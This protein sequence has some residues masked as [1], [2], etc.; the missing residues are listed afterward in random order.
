M[1][2]VRPLSHRRPPPPLTEFVYPAVQDD[3][4]GSLDDNV[5]SRAKPIV[6]GGEAETQVRSLWPAGDVDWIK[7]DLVAN[8]VYEFSASKL[9]A[10]C[11]THMSL[12]RDNGVGQSITL[13]MSNG[14]WIGYDSN[15]QYYSAVGGI[16]YIEVRSD[17]EFGVGVASYELSARELVN[18]DGDLYSAY[19]DCDDTD[20]AIFPYQTETAGDGVDQN[21][22]WTDWPLGDDA[23]S[24]GSDGTVAEAVDMHETK[25][26]PFE[27]IWQGQTYLKNTRTI[28]PANDVDYFKVTV[29][30][31]SASYVELV[32]LDSGFSLTG[33]LYDSDGTTVLYSDLLAPNDAGYIPIMENANGSPKEFYIS[34]TA[35]TTGAYLPVLY[36]VGT[37][38][39][40]DQYYNQDWVGARDC[41]DG[42]AAIHPDATE[43]LGDGIDSNCNGDDDS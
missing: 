38:G 8:I 36:S 4:E 28:A 39:D 20:A 24:A 7:I 23:D 25:G 6:V 2:V 32:Q 34:F 13:V 21:C 1:V 40:G 30:A 41:N 19:H 12:Y 14:D 35:A 17:D 15:I 3:Y 11:D 16:F 26:D 37:D 27:I 10:T 31:Y 33:T 9:C 18:G 29:P 42:D 5:K 22:S 43:V